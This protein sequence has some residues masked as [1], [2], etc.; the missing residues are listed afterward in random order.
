MHWTVR[1]C[2]MVMAS[3]LVALGLVESASAVEGPLAGWHFDQIVGDGFSPDY[4]G[5]NFDLQEGGIIAAGGR[6]G[7]AL[8][9]DGSDSLDHV[10][11]T[12]LE[13]GAVTVVSWVKS[14]GD[15]QPGNYRYVLAKGGSTGCQ[16]PSYGLYTGPPGGG[17]DFYFTDGAGTIH[18]SPAASPAALWD[19]QWHAVAG[20]Y[21][22]SSV[23]LYVDGSQVG[24]GTPASGAISYDRPISDVTVGN[25]VV[26]SCGL[27]GFSGRID[28]TR[29]Y[30]RALTSAEI[31]RL[32]D[33]SA[34]SP[35]DLSIPPPTGPPPTNSP[36]AGVPVATVLARGAKTFRVK[37]SKIGG[38]GSAWLSAKGSRPGAGATIDSYLWDFDGNGTTDTICPPDAPAVLHQY[39]KP[40]NYKVVVSARDSTGATAQTATAV[41]TFRKK[42]RRS[43]SNRSGAGASAK[44]LSKRAIESSACISQNEEQQPS[45]AD[46][47]RTFHFGVVDVNA[48][49]ENCFKLE[50]EFAGNRIRPAKVSRTF[51]VAGGIKRYYDASVKGSVALDGLPIPLPRSHESQYSSIDGSIRLGRR[52]VE[53]DLDGRRVK[54]ASLNLTRN[55]LGGRTYDLGAVH[56]TGIGKIGGLP[57]SGRASLDFVAPGETRLNLSVK[58]PDVFSMAD[59]GPAEGTVRVSAGNTRPFRISSFHIHIPNVYLGPVLARD[60]DLSYDEAGDTWSGGAAFLLPGMEPPFVLDAA[61]RPGTDYGVQFSNGQLKHAGAEVDFGALA[62]Q[63][64]PGVFL[65]QLRFT[66]GTDPVR[67]FAGGTLS[68]ARIAY[69]DGAILMVFPDSG[70]SWVVPSGLAGFER[71]AGRRID[72]LAVG[73]GG[74]VYYKILGLDLHLGNGFFLYTYP[75]RFDFGGGFDLPLGVIHAK[76]EISGALDVGS[77]KFNTEG[78]GEVCVAEIDGCIGADVLVSTNGLA[79]CGRISLIFDEISIGAGYHWGG[80]FHFYPWGCDVGSYREQFSSAGARAATSGPVKF[81]LKPGLPFAVQEIKG[82]DGAPDVTFNGP[83]GETFST[84]GQDKGIDGDLAFLRIPGNKTTYLGLKNPSAGT[85]T[86][87]PNSG[88]APIESFSAADGLKPPSVKARVTG[89]GKRRTIDYRVAPRPGQ[90]VTFFEIGSD[91][92]S[93]IGLAKGK[94]GSLRFKPARGSA[95]KRRLLALV[96]HDGVTS[97]RL[98]VATFRAPGWREPRRPRRLRV[99][100]KGKTIELRWKHQRGVRRYAV[101]VRTADGIARMRIVKKSKL[102]MKRIPR[103][104]G[105]TVAVTGLAID[106]THG[107]VKKSRFKRARR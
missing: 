79:G 4:T 59:G 93:R 2:L 16:T 70:E 91:T 69:V 8:L 28:E 88:S 14:I 9:L 102:K 15:T 56:P 66:F 87:T 11:A 52:D 41:N 36:Q 84:G 71:L 86:V 34:T 92:Y 67:I 51:K 54:I 37:G 107:P 62:P 48:R 82:E 33:P 12:G 19:G 17:M 77:A 3:I 98:K 13:P 23:R 25:Y 22:G 96:S 106:G 97:S 47:I 7:N 24:T 60:L 53:F 64:F 73:G 20:S 85:W 50:A 65:S 72:S 103:S 35:P 75:G 5:H 39:A 78:H 30:G 46:C 27:F 42:S 45:T 55:G 61:P 10:E 43:A 76:A 89:K 44:R 80:A 1:I 74:G 18:A 68:V 104:M 57:G 31:S 49:S 29:V 38:A 83:K 63:V 58:L 95:G 21:D 6:W 32:A 94:K 99:R 81:R 40:G 100:R 26:A 105:G 90:K 101:N